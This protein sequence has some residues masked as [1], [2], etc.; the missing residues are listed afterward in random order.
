MEMQDM[1][2]VIPFL[3]GSAFMLCL[4]LSY[5]ILKYCTDKS[6]KDSEAQVF[7]REKE[8]VF[9]NILINVFFIHAVLHNLNSQ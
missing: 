9:N 7:S 1:I 8:D 6:I 5:L 3:T 4:A 2:L